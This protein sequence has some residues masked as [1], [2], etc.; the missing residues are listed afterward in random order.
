MS[1]FKEILLS[2]IIFIWHKV[3][4]FI[5]LARKHFARNAFSSIGLFLT[6]VIVFISTGL[7]QPMKKYYR[8]KM[9]GSLP[10]TM[11]RVMA[12]QSDQRE[13][14]GF[15]NFR[16]DAF[17][18]ISLAQARALKEKKGI[19]GIYYTQMLQTPASA[20]VDSALFT[21]FGFRFDIM[22]Q[23]ISAELAR[24]YL[25]C[26]KNFHTS[27][28]TTPEGSFPLLPIIIPQAYADII[29]AYSMVNGLPSF[30]TNFL[31]GLRL[32]IQL[33]KSI[34]GF[35]DDFTETVY[36]QICGFVPDGYVRVAGVPL[37]WVENFHRQKK[38]YKSL[39]SYDSIFLKVQNVTLLDDVKD[40]VRRMGLIIPEK[41]GSYSS[42]LQW[43]NY[44]DY[45][46]WG[47]GIL[48][49]ILSSVAMINAFSL[50]S[51]EKK[52]EFGLYLVFGSS[53]MFIWILMF[54][55]GALWGIIHSAAAFYL[56]DWMVALLQNRMAAPLAAGA[57]F[58]ENWG[59]ISLQIDESFK[60]GVTL[61]AALL[62]GFTSFLPAFI[63]MRKNVLSLI[64]KD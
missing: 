42:L 57:Y 14:T 48:L 34:M 54:F 25:R 31:T 63:M 23:G 3:Y 45:I 4:L 52:Y 11:I 49:A 7:F 56:S 38:K 12:T 44:L 37:S 13:V 17:L 32:K 15:L 21:Q 24:P 1:N 60:A 28:H 16:K 9:I 5:Y 53:P 64:K 18:G 8:E 51:I 43:M 41:T 30:K 46:F 36:G 62:S 39:N 40:S 61:A 33:G 50:L 27:V 19:T 26:M 22:A 2:G 47:V 6:L 58:A 59:N 55:E 29:Y 10:S 35:E 20:Q